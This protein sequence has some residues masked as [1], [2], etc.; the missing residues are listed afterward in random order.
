MSRMPTFFLSHGGGPWPYIPDMRNQFVRSAAW[1]EGLPTALPTQPKAILS[2]SAHWETPE[3]CVSTAEKPPMIYDYSGFPPHTY[4]IA[5]GA[6]GAPDIARRIQNRLLSAG[7][8]ASE[9]PTRGFDHGTF[10]PLGLMY[11]SAEIPV[12]SMSIKANYSP[13]EH[14]EAGEALEGL[15]DEGILIIGSGLSYHN[16]RGFGRSES[17]GISERFGAWLQETI[18]ESDVGLRRRRLIGWETAPFSRQA[19]PR[20]DHLV[21]LML[22]CGAAGRDQGHAVFTDHVMGV[23]MASYRFG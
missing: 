12:V 11:P 2:V 6:P 4:H 8:L 17:K 5:Y 20:E 14:L 23:D 10:V 15:R 19:H 13:L 21:P 7:I 3:F 16:M 22:V 18:E 9:S 1:L